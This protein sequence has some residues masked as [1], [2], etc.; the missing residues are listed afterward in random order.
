M[1]GEES[2]PLPL[3]EPAEDESVPVPNWLSYDP[4]VK[5]DAESP[6]GLPVPTSAPRMNA[7]RGCHSVSPWKLSGGTT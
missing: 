1:A 7:E 6:P 2:F 4:E 5:R 3:P